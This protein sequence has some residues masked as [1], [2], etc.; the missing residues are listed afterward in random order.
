MDDEMSRS[1]DALNAS[2]QGK[3]DDAA[4][5]A[6]ALASESS[7][8]ATASMQSAKKG[9]VRGSTRGLAPMDA[10][11]RPL[12]QGASKQWPAMPF[13]GGGGWGRGR[14]I[15]GPD[16]SR[17][18]LR[19]R[20]NAHMPSK[21]TTAGF[22]AH[23]NPEP[24][25]PQAHLEPPPMGTNTLPPMGFNA[26]KDAT[27]PPP[28]GTQEPANATKPNDGN[29]TTPDEGV[30]NRQPHMGIDPTAAHAE[31]PPKAAEGA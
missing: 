6:A 14:P 1:S 3:P 2:P 16:T 20:L 23:G 7:S 19:T 17:N 30:G 25:H 22:P 26:S 13:N 31:A 21:G 4:E 8:L 28:K 12:R 9:P 11:A 18:S 24:A 5:I 15:R 27:A 10:T 29:Y